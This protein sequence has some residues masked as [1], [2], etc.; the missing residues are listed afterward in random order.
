MKNKIVFTL[1]FGFISSVYAQPIISS[2]SPKKGKPGATVVLSGSGFNSSASDNIVRIGGIQCSVTSGSSTSLTVV[3]PDQITTEYFYVTDVPNTLMAKS[4]TKFIAQTDSTNTNISA[5][6][7]KGKIS[8]P[9]GNS[10]GYLNKAFGMADLDEDGDFDFAMYENTSTHLKYVSNDWS[11][12]T[13]TN[14]DFTTSILKYAATPSGDPVKTTALVDI[15]S[16]GDLDFYLGKSGFAASGHSSRIYLNNSSSSFS[17]DTVPVILTALTNFAANPQFA[18]LNRDGLMDFVSSY[19]WNE[20]PS[21]NK[22]TNPPSFGQYILNNTSLGAASNNTTLDINSD[23]IFDIAFTGDNATYGFKWA[24]NNTAVNAASTAFSFSS[25]SSLATQ[26]SNSG[27]WEGDLNNDD[28]Q[29]ILVFRNNSATVFQNNSTSTSSYGFASGINLSI[30]SL[31]FYAVQFA[32]FNN[33]GLL[34]IIAGTNNVAGNAVYFYQNT[35]TS[36]GGT[37]SFAAG[38]KLIDNIGNVVQQ[39]EVVDINEDGFQDIITKGTSTTTLE[40]YLNLKDQMPSY[41]VKSTGVSALGT[42][43]NW[44]NLPDGTGGNPPSFATN[45]YFNLSNSSNSTTFALGSNL[46]L[47]AGQLVIPSGAT[48]NITT[49]R[50][51][52][53]NG[54]TISNSGTISGNVGT[55]VISGTGNVT[56]TGTMSTGTFTLNTSGNVTVASTATLNIYNIL[57]LTSVGTF[58]T[59]GNVNLKSLSTRTAIMGAASGTVS[60]NINCELYIAGG[61][62]KFR[63]LAHPFSSNQNLSLLTDD[64]DITGSGGSSNGFTS[65]VANN[66]SAFWFN[67]ANGDGATYDAGWTAFTSASGGTGNVWAPGKGIRTLIR[68]AKN[69]GLDGS[70]YTPSAVTLDMSGPVNIGDVTVNLDYAGSNNSQG[71]NLLGN[72]YASPIDVSSL[73]YNSSTVSNINKTI[74]TRN[75]RQGSYTTDVITSGTV[76]SIPAYS[77]F[78]LKTSAS[79]ASVTFTESMKQTTSSISTF[80]GMG[81]EQ[82]PNLLRIS[83]LIRKEQFDKVDFHFG[84]EYGDTLD[85]VY[86]AFKM[87]NDY[88][89]LYSLTSNKSKVAI[90]FRNLDT[91][92]LIPLGLSI[93]KNAKDTIELVFDA[94]NTNAGLYL[95]DYLTQVKTPIKAGNTYTITVDANEPETIGDN[96]L[97]IGSI[98]A[99]EQLSTKLKNEICMTVYPNPVRDILNIQTL[100]YHRIAKVKLFNLSGIEILHSDIDFSDSKIGS[101]DTK[102]LESGI[103]LV[104]V[105]AENGQKYTTKVIK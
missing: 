88:F 75:A 100:N 56:L 89:N 44:T 34:D 36:T 25:I 58:T 90:D 66:P 27:I 74:Y 48:L 31:S 45:G 18:D 8:M 50:I 22:G 13:M 102:N 7:F 47:S 99:L 69:E 51:L 96:R 104:E 4:F 16:D 42:L 37:I 98:S 33:D 93:A 84:N 24:V 60:G 83:A 35:T 94:N 46:T 1:L 21:E 38:V 85:K 103:Y 82:T 39:I 97:V 26:Q 73:V 10:G 57:N 91:L 40:I 65:T 62:R 15:D 3:L 59:N 23:G 52:T 61:Y 11:S 72:P 105:I 29:D 63:F 12:G 77:A 17:I 54:A 67:P 79:S 9:V 70:T 49:S 101:I 19:T 43:T 68:G 86:D 41:Y 64:I 81:D 76:Y 87:I 95:Y 53:L 30:S 92:K 55:I 80:L 71:L 28:K 6:T 14:S 2:F 20:Y 78:F 32:D 5:T